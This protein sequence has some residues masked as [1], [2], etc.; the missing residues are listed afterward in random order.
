MMALEVR[1]Q[2]TFATIM[3]QHRGITTGFDYLRIILAL[4]VVLWHSIL[5]TTG[6]DTHIWS[7]LLRPVPAIILPMFFCLSGFLVAG[8]LIRTPTMR[9]FLLLRAIRIIPALFVEVILAALILGPLLTTLPITDYFSNTSFHHYFLNIFGMV[10][11]YLPG[12]F[13]DNIFPDVV[14]INLRTLPSEL[15]CYVLLAILATLKITKKPLLLAALSIIFLIFLTIQI[16]PYADDLQKTPPLGKT[17]VLAFIFGVVFNLLKE[18]IPHR[19][20]WFVVALISM[21]LLLLKASTQFI[22]LP[23]IAYVTG[24]LG[25]LTPKKKTFLLR[26]DYSYGLYLFG[27]PLQQVYAMLFASNLSWLGS[28]IFTLTLGLGYAYLSWNFIEKPILQKKNI[29]ISNLN[30]A[31][32]YAIS[33]I[34]YFGKKI[35]FRP[36]KI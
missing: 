4:S 19:K 6:Q 2:E 20:V 14:N 8:S 15:E 36:K 28:V 26:G 35:G 7:G 13:A 5:T 9:D 22:S 10:Y 27:F 3:A 11:L 34:K 18:H 32:E 33:P 12:M 21:I 17:L 30:S 25:L 29:I 16:L 23:F 31:Y 24:Y 1:K